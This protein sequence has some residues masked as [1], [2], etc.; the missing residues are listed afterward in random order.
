MLHYFLIGTYHFIITYQY[1]NPAVSFP[2][3][4]NA[5]TIH[6]CSCRAYYKDPCILFMSLSKCIITK[7]DLNGTFPSSLSCVLKVPLMPVNECVEGRNL[8]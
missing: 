2:V 7:R 4:S 3:Y 1:S 8:M 6:I 5:A